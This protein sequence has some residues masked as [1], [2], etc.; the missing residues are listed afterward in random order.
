MKYHYHN[1]VHRQILHKERFS[2]K[3]E[4]FNTMSFMYNLTVAKIVGANGAGSLVTTVQQPEKPV[5]HTRTALPSSLSI[6]A[7]PSH[8]LN[9]EDVGAIWLQSSSTSPPLSMTSL[10]PPPPLPPPP[11]RDPPL[12]LQARSTKTRSSRMVGGTRLNATATAATIGQQMNMCGGIGVGG[13][14]IAMQP[15]IVVVDGIAA[16]ASIS[17]TSSP[18]SSSSSSSPSSNVIGGRHVSLHATTRR[19]Q[20]SNRTYLDRGRSS[21]ALMNSDMRSRIIESIRRRPMLWMGRKG[22]NRGQNRTLVAWKEVAIEM[23]LAPSKNRFLFLFFFCVLL[24]I[25]MYK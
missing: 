5:I 7:I 25:Y 12:P 1:L 14:G 19:R 22:V 2:T 9:I 21:A 17:S 15:N 6:T 16:T 20:M 11:T 23:E 4:H 18:S 13:V 10:P 24:Y 3:W 8:G